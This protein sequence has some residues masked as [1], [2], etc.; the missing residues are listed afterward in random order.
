MTNFNIYNDFLKGYEFSN[1]AEIKINNKQPNG[2]SR[3]DI[4]FKIFK[5]KKIIHV[6]CV[7]HLELIDEKIKNNTW[8]HAQIDKISGLTIGIDINEKGI[9]KNE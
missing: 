5:E 4:L 7:D 3:E 2:I 6:G 9:K 8:I 1:A